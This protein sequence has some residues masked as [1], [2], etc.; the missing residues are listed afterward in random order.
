[1]FALKVAVFW[2]CITQTSQYA[3]ELSV[4][5][6]MKE[7]NV[8]LVDLE[9]TSC[10]GTPIKSVSAYA[11]IYL[12]ARNLAIAEATGLTDLLTVCNGCHLSFTEAMRFLKADEALRAR[13]SSLMSEEGLT[14]EGSVNVWHVMDFLHDVIKKEAITK[15]V[16]RS[17]KGLRLAVHYGCHI[18]RPSPLGRPDDPEEPRKLDDLVEWIGAVSVNY[19]EKLDCCGA[20]LMLS[21]PDGALTM[22]GSKLKALRECDVDGL[23]VI[24]PSCHRMFDER[25][26]SAGAAVGVDVRVPTLYYAQLLGISMGIDEEE[27]GLHLNRSPVDELLSKVKDALSP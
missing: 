11:S 8:E 2:G 26:R 1:M 23:V 22:A 15:A 16:K 20:M 7:L 6:I 4:R 25:Q 10:C 24:C 9:G 3:C 13:V 5:R 27:L 19:S 21:R 17:L 18:I 12:A 14:Y